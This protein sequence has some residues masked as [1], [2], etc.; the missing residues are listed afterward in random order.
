MNPIRPKTDVSSILFKSPS[1]SD[2][3]NLLQNLTFF[4]GVWCCQLYNIKEYPMSNIL[5]FFAF[6]MHSFVFVSVSHFEALVLA[7]HHLGIYLE[8]ISASG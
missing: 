8:I 3:C 1:F 7:V 6:L 4:T 5:N 2:P